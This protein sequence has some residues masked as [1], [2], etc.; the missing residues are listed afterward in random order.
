MSYSGYITV[1]VVWNDGTVEEI[2]VEGYS[3]V[4]VKDG[5]LHVQLAD[6]REIRHIPLA[7]IREWRMPEYN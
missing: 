4:T 5:I 1:T 6:S 7:S 3:P 2:R